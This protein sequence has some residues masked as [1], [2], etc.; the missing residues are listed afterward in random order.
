MKRL[1]KKYFPLIPAF[2]AVGVSLFSPSCANTTQAPT[3]GKKDTIPPVV[4]AVS[5]ALGAL[6]VPVHD[7]KV[8][9]SFNEYVTV[10]EPKAIYLSP[11]L[12]KQPR[13]KLKGKSV[14]VYFEEDLQ[15]NTTYTLDVTGA[16]ADNNEGNK[17]PGYTAVFSTGS[18]IDTML[19]TG[20]VVDCNTLKPIQGAT[21]M[22]YKDP[23]DSAVFLRRPYASARTDD[24]GYFSLRNIQDTLYRIYAVVDGNGNNLY[25]PDE[26]RIA[27]SD[28][29]VRPHRFVADSL[30]ELT[31][32]DMKDT[33][34]CLARGTDMT[35]NVFRE[36]PSK[37]MLMNKMRLSDRSAY[38]TFNAPDTRI[39]SL[40]F[41]GIA[42]NRVIAQFNP[43]RDSLELWVNDRR[44]IPDTLHLNIIY[45]KTDSTGTLKPV[46]E[47]VRLFD[48]NKPKG[49]PTRKKLEHKDTVCQMTLTG[50]P[51]TVE[52]LG[53][54][55]E[56]AFPPVYAHFD[57]LVL[58]S[59][60][61]KQQEAVE[62]FTW[63]RDSLNLRKY[64]FRPSGILQTGFDYIFKV[65]SRTFRDINGFW[66]DSTQVKVTLP[67]DESLSSLTLR[68]Q[69]VGGRRYIVDLL[70]E[71]RNQILR[72]YQIEADADLL[73]PY[74]KKGKYSVRITEDVNRNGIV[75]TG[76]LLARRQPEKVK[77]LQ[78]NREDTVDIPEKTEL[79]QD[80]NLVEVFKK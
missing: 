69:G 8:V 71:K 58:K 47:N 30:P 80:V 24:W 1:I 23:A 19:L 3:G 15:P 68:M 63:E 64:S 31:K 60:N 65:P 66:N 5:P 46:T 52:Q 17:F 28:T 70:N 27:F 36:R 6:N 26:D 56:F 61:P 45:W 48:E 50:K 32:Y 44:R 37:Q 73:F 41:K 51:E 39:D 2:V 18:A 16:I 40:W 53:F 42:P 25:D 11:P 13:F 34:H 20:T 38:V 72:T 49:K 4:T 74:L 62:R 55:I 29:L 9:F 22:L 33:V 14:V 57:S 10:K 78:F 59:V 43:R 21:V 7:T 75:D 77:F 35:L 76:L 54:E 12:K 79:S 67:T